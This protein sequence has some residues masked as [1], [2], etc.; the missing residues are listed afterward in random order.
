[1]R[2]PGVRILLP[3]DLRLRTAAKPKFPSRAKIEYANPIAADDCRVL[4]WCQRQ[5]SRRKSVGKTDAP[6]ASASVDGFMAPLGAG[7]ASLAATLAGGTGIG[8]WLLPLSD[9]FRAGNSLVSNCSNSLVAS[10]SS[11]FSV[12]I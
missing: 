2:R 4:Q 3:P 11:R 12:S 9:S 7:V 1:M 8:C 10:A 6:G 5:R